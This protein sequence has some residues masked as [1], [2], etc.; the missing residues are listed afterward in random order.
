M[1]GNNSRYTAEYRRRALYV[2]AFDRMVE[3]R[4]TDGLPTEWKNGEEVMRWW[5]ND[6]PK[7]G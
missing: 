6:N 7:E 3:K 1:I 4:K 2:R 5:L